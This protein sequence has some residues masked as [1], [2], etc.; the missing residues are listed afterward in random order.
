MEK[1]KILLL[2]IAFFFIMA[3]SF[4]LLKLEKKEVQMPGYKTYFK[5]STTDAN[6]ILQTYG[7][8][9]YEIKSPVPAENK[10][11]TNTAN[12]LCMESKIYSAGASYPVLNYQ[13]DSSLSVT[14]YNKYGYPNTDDTKIIMPG[15]HS[16]NLT[17]VLLKCQ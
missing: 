5:D 12:T 10:N 4:L 11:E 15:Q 13:C 7:T 1:P 3:S 8:A 16:N 14:I 17:S 9:V 2:L 6:I